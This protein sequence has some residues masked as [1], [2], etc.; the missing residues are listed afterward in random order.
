MPC[1]SGNTPVAGETKKDAV[2]YVFKVTSLQQPVMT[3]ESG[4]SPSTLAFDVPARQ[5]YAQNNLRQLIVFS[6]TGDKIKDYTLVKGKDSSNIKFLVHPDGRS[7]LVLI[8]GT[9]QWVTLP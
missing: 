6:P 3:I 1:K 9:L 5:I 7:L 8:S 2:T 4:P